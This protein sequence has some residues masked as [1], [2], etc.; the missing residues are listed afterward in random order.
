MLVNAAFALILISQRNEREA[1][2]AQT[3]EEIVNVM[4]KL[5]VSMA[6]SIIPGDQSYHEYLFERSSAAEAKI[7]SVFLGDPSV[8]DKGGSIFV[9]ESPSGTMTFRKGGSVELEL[10]SAVGNLERKLE[11]GGIKFSRIGDTYYSL[12][13]GKPI[14]NGTLRFSTSN[15]GISFGGICMLGELRQISDIL[16][17]GSIAILLKF[18]EQMSDNGEV[19]T[20]I[21]AI[22][23]G[24]L[25]VST[26]S[27]LELKPVWKISTDGGSRLVLLSDGSIA[28]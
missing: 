26:S 4:E 17:P 9:Y 13:D 2:L 15:R 1:Q 23:N 10:K 12:Y 25:L 3:N 24:Y 11:A 27:V 28:D 7:A 8:V 16:F 18:K 20:E 22:E 5:G 21:Q 19:F 14:F 6:S